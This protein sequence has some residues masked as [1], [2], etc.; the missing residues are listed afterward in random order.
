MTVDR[1][2]HRSRIAEVTAEVIAREG[3]EAATVRRIA[4]AAGYSTSIV[5][6]YFADK[7]ELLV[8]AYRA[9]DK[10]LRGKINAVL[11]R[12]PADLVGC[13]LCMTAAEEVSINR[14]RTYVALWGHAARDESWAQQER[15]DVES[16]IS[17]IRDV[18]RTRNGE[19]ASI[20]AMSRNLNAYIQG[21]SVQALINPA[22]WSRQ[23]I[24]EA[25]EALVDKFVGSRTAP[26][27]QHPVAARD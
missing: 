2:E 8:A 22:R 26:Q 1:E 23:E 3:V 18:I 24:Q 6:Y 25:I 10:E 13:L 20:D 9:L 11:G 4:A 15:I 21:I 17:L 27:G 19:I 12:D 14:W 5:T 16:A 7:H